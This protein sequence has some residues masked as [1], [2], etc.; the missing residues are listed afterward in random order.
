[1]RPFVEPFTEPDSW[2]VVLREQEPGSFRVENGRGTLT[3]T[4]H[5]HDFPEDLECGF[6]HLPDRDYISVYTKQLMSVTKGYRLRC[7]VQ[8]T[9]DDG[10][11]TEVESFKPGWGALW[12]FEWSSRRIWYYL[13]HGNMLQFADFQGAV[14]GDPSTFPVLRFDVTVQFD[15]V[16]VKVFDV[17]N[18]QML[19]ERVDVPNWGPYT[20]VVDQFAIDFVAT[21]QARTTPET[22]V[23]ISIDSISLQP[24]P[25]W[26]RL[27]SWFRR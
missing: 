24:L 26:R 11:M 17:T 18:N 10:Q 15:R 27:W 16:A 14:E 13:P 7:Q 3:A 9:A 21:S 8:R 5:L 20:R 6:P 2:Q 22:P 4:K 1:M 23:A 12:H 25:W 19:I